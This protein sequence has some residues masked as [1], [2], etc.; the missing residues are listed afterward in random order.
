M[1]FA[2]GSLKIKK[3]IDFTVFT[4]ILQQNDLPGRLCVSVVQLA[5]LGLGE[6]VDPGAGVD[7]N[8]EELSEKNS[9]S[10]FR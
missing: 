6:V 2:L 4:A 1:A 3:N 7:C 9:R 8:H 10:I 5:D